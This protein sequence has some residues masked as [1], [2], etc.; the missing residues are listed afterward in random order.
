MY[1]KILLIALCGVLLFGVTGCG[2]KNQ[3]TGTNND[4]EKKE[5]NQDIVMTCT[6][7]SKPENEYEANS[8]TTEV[9]T[10]DNNMI[11]K[12]VEIITD[13]EYS[14]EER[15]NSQK[16]IHED[17][18]NRV[19]EIE[20]ISGSIETKSNTRFVYSYIYDLE[21]IANLEWV[22]GSEADTSYFD[23]S[24]HEFNADKYAEGFENVNN[25]ELSS[26]TCVIE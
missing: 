18:V 20:G 5:S 24:T 4:T 22:L 13:E 10:Y 7:N 23:Y 8:T 26:G 11:L 9:Y 15:A 19:N 3:N 1:K 25:S 14:N 21:K 12:K 17:A 6:A 2:S 16:S